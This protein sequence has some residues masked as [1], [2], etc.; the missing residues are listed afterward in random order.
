MKFTQDEYDTLKAY[1]KKY[2]GL[3]VLVED[4]TG[5]NFDCV[6]QLKELGIKGIYR[7]IKKEK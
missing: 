7:K 2:P 5:E 6:E 4:P 1:K 3:K